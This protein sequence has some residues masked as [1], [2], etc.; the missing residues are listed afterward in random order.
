MKELS[1]EKQRFVFHIF[2]DS[3]GDDG[4]EIGMGLLNEGNLE[5]RVVIID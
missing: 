4:V 3:L 2:C 5:L 1:F